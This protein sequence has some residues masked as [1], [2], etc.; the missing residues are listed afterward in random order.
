MRMDVWWSVVDSSI[1]MKI[2]Q[3]YLTVAER[4]AACVDHFVNIDPESSWVR[5]AKE[6][7]CRQQV[8]AVEE[9]KSYLPPRGESDVAYTLGVGSPS[10]VESCPYLRD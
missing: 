5:L 8:A 3:Q 10:A 1:F 4:E 2:K 6:L 7:Y 9:V